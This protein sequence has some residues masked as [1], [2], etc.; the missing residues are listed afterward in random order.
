MD[1][2]WVRGV[3]V[4]AQRVPSRVERVPSQLVVHP[5]IGKHPAVMLPALLNDKNE[6]C[7]ITVPA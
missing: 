7:Y 4:Q 6:E 2:Q 5:G 1:S 3:S